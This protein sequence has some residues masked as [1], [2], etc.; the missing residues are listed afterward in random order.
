MLYEVGHLPA[1]VNLN[2]HIAVQDPVSGD[3]IDQKG[4]EQLTSRWGVDN[5]TTIA[6]YGDQN[7]WFACCEK[8]LLVKRSQRGWHL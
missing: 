3:F 8:H 5:E 6:R 2:W 4:L 7:N 1:A